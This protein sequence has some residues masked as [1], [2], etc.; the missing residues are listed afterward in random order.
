MKKFLS[1]LFVLGLALSAC[2]T[3]QTQSVPFAQTSTPTLSPTRT[4]TSTATQTRI[5]PTATIT[6]LPTIPTFTP[7]ATQRVINSIDA[8]ELFSDRKP[9]DIA[10]LIWDVVKSVRTKSCPTAKMEVASKEQLEGLIFL[11]ADARKDYGITRVY[12]CGDSSSIYQFQIYARKNWEDEEGGSHKNFTSQATSEWAPALLLYR[13]PSLVT[14]PLALTEE[15]H[16]G[17]AMFHACNGGDPGIDW[18]R[19]GGYDW[20]TT[21]P[22]LKTVKLHYP[23]FAVTVPREV[24]NQLD[25][26]PPNGKRILL[27]GWSEN[28]EGY[29]SCLSYLEN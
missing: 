10:K 13:L 20:Y 23:H 14:Y 8:A 19:W 22:D 29:S 26:E 5:P 17:V 16:R 11:P 1:L 7:T 27:S 2:G 3:S 9:S 18:E 24:F 6:P 15:Q 28:G 4:M 12:L 25:M 21:D